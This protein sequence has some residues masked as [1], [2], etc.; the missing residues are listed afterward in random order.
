MKMEWRWREARKSLSEKSG[1]PQNRISR[2]IRKLCQL[3][4]ARPQF[5]G[6]VQ[7]LLLWMQCREGS[8]S[9]STPKSGC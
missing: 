8:Q 6:N 1:G 9:S 7:K 3:E 5:S 2:D 4:T